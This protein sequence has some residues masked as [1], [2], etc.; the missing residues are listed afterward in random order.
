LTTILDAFSAV[1]P[2]TAHAIARDLARDEDASVFVRFV[3]QCILK[4]K[5]PM[6]PDEPEPMRRC[7][8]LDLYFGDALRDAERVSDHVEPYAT[9]RSVILAAHEHQLD[10]DPQYRQHID[11][12]AAAATRDAR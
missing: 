10:T 1:E 2:S 6:Q 12:L 8:P 9:I 11:L 4:G 7:L 3:G 5:D